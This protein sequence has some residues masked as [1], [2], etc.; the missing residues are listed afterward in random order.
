MNIGIFEDSG[1]RS[2]L[3]LTWLRPAFSLACGTDRLIDRIRRYVPGKL[4]RLWVRDAL[5]TVTADLVEGDSPAN[6]DDW[7]LINSRALITDTLPDLPPESLWAIHGTVVAARV[8]SADISKITSLTFLDDAKFG[9]WAST[10]RSE[11]PPP[12]IRLIQ[13]P[14]DLIAA[15]P[16]ELR[17]QMQ[18][19][20]VRAGTVHGGA[21]LL[22]EG[23]IHIAAGAVVKPGAVLDAS[24]GPIHISEYATI[25]P[26]AVVQGPCFVGE[27]AIVRPNAII[28][29]DT[30]IGPVCKVGGEIEA[31]VFWGYSNKQ[32]DGFLGHSYVGPWVNLGA[33]T[34]T[35]DLKNTYGSIRALIN[36]VGVETGLH[37]LGS[38]IGDHT[39]TGIGTILP[40]GCVIGVASNVFTQNVVPRFVPSFAWLTEKG[41][42]TYRTDKAIQI[43]RIVLERRKLEFT[44]DEAALFE[45]TARSCKDVEKPGWEAA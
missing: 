28:R 12:Q 5:K 23:L 26:N 41:I 24:D 30:S 44:D 25:E 14:W 1:Y 10:F 22:N 13:Y 37:F 35:S 36:G 8:S 3:P 6:D 34:T 9:E 27:R 19:G 39:K 20:G 38:I 33:G 2:L 32:H 31:S 15:N 16:E 40:T 4:A 17:R 42:T 7:W 11:P 43:A 21:H 29:G 45:V 18:H